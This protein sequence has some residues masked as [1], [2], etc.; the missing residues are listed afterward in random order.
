MTAAGIALPAVSGR[1]RASGPL[2]VVLAA[3]TAAYSVLQS[4]VVPALGTLQRE[5]HTGPTGT[6]CRMPASAGLK[7]RQSMMW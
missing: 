4:F 2:L 5:L 6:A 7:L 1:D 3:A